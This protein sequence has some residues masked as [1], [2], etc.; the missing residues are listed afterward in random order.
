MITSAQ[1]RRQRRKLKET[2]RAIPGMP[3]VCSTVMTRLNDPNAD[4]KQIAE[5]LRYDPGLTANVLKLANSAAYGGGQEVDSLQAAFVRL[6]LKRLMQLV[7]AEGASDL[8]QRELGGY[9]LRPDEFL[10][11]SVWTAVA[12]ET[13]AEVLTLDSSDLLFTA[14]LLHDLGKLALDDHVAAAADELMG[15][16]AA[17]DASSFDHAEDA[18]LGMSHAEAGAWLMSAWNFPEELVEA[19]RFHHCPG[20]MTEA[21][22]Q[23]RLTA[24][25]VHLSDMLAYS[26]GLGTGVDGA[27]YALDDAAVEALGL[28]EDALEYVAA[29]TVETYEELKTSLLEAQT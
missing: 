16:L 18:R 22:E 7:I 11:H 15:V 1:R 9:G 28:K 29:Q 5:E 19:T 2:L 25:I 23:A 17:G 3:A 20:A 4:F 12:A 24:D 13:F 8:L 27:H 26:T 10:A 14:G 6:G 21:S